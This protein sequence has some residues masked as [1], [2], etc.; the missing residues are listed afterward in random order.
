MR[1]SDASLVSGV[2]NL[3]LRFTFLRTPD[4]WISTFFSRF[5]VCFF[6]FSIENILR[7]FHAII[8]SSSFEN[9]KKSMGENFSTSKLAKSA[10]RQSHPRCWNSEDNKMVLDRPSKETKL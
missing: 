6:G 2:I 5:F 8:S 1:Y 4:H 7:K 3:L 10:L 9:K